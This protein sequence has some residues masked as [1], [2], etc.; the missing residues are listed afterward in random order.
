M[1]IQVIRPRKVLN[2]SFSGLNHLDDL[3][4]N[5]ANLHWELD[6]GNNTKVATGELGVE[7]LHFPLVLLIL[8][9]ELK[10]EILVSL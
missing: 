6:Y 9:A 4:T 8:C 7:G 10:I 2:W 3:K 1:L 5:A